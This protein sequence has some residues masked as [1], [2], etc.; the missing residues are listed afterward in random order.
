M[1]TYKSITPM[2]NKIT[3]LLL[4][5]H[6]SV[7]IAVAQ[8]VTMQNVEYKGWKNNIKLSNGEVD[9]IAT[10]EVGPRIIFF[11]PPGGDNVF[12]NYDEMM[13]KSGEKDWKIRGGH[14]LWVAPENMDITYC[15][16]N[17]P[18][19]W[20]PIG[21][22]GVRLTPKPETAVGFQKQ[23][24]IVLD[25]KA[26][27]VR[28]THR[29][30]NIGGKTVHMAP[31]AVSVMA[32]GGF[33]IIPQPKPIPH[34]QGL[35]PNR[36]LV[37]WPFTNLQDG[38]YYLG[39]NYFALSQ[40]NSKGPTKIGL[41]NQQKSAAYLR[42]GLLF[43]KTFPYQQDKPYVDKGANFETF[44]NKDMLELESVGPLVKL[45]PGQKVE[46]VEDWYL[47]TGLPALKPNHEAEIEET[48]LPKIKSIPLPE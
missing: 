47:F 32:P 7:A 41:V 14:R 26:A 33:A 45:A 4:A 16:D 20:K 9:L 36:Q 23:L 48:I 1:V 25:A 39:V 17:G 44:A 24:D 21:K 2:K 43:V 13:G 19:D 37:L 29:I 38:R 31:W 35:L 46:H 10:L 18:V 8:E 28:I 11:G 42:G 34:P 27:H 40:D 6:L 22:N 15:P 30:E 3:G 5:A 12:K